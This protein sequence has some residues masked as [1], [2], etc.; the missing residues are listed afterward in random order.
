MHDIR[1]PQK[2]QY[3]LM[4]QRSQDLHLPQRIQYI[5]LPKI[6][7][8]L[9]VKRE[10]LPGQEEGVILLCQKRPYILLCPGNS[11]SPEEPVPPR[12]V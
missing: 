11:S 3:L 9:L 5:F 7:Q 10:S 6:I 8:H 4:P 12:A 2:R 1:M